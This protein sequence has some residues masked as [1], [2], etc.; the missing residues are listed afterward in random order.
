MFDVWLMMKVQHESPKV[1]NIGFYFTYKRPFAW[2]K[3]S[4]AHKS[5]LK[6]TE[7]HPAAYPEFSEQ[8]GTATLESLFEKHTF[9]YLLV[10]V[11]VSSSLERTSVFKS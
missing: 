7:H 2:H 4:T 9:L 6:A 11:F 8:T 3:T 10:P 1:F 5:K